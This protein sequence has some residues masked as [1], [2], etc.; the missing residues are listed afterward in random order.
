MAMVIPRVRDHLAGP[1][2]R[3]RVALLRETPLD[4]PSE[5]CTCPLVIKQGSDITQDSLSRTTR[6]LSAAPLV[7][8]CSLVSSG[9][10]ISSGPPSS[11]PVLMLWQGGVLV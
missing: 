10:G 1:H 2:S 4:D 7:W 3:A 5:S 8:R 11:Q 6:S 9:S